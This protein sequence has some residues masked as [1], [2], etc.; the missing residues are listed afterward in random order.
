MKLGYSV[1]IILIVV[2][3]IFFALRSAK[4]NPEPV[5]ENN[6]QSMNTE[7]TNEETLPT[8]DE[9]LMTTVKEGS[10]DEAKDGDVITVNYTGYFADGTVFFSCVGKTP[11]QSTL[12]AGQVIA[13]WD[14]GVK[15]MKKGEVRR[16]VIPADMAYGEAGRPGIPPN[17]TLAFEVELLEIAP[18]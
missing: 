17:S 9:L 10:G 14:V 2:V 7:N 8:S 18:K 13:G 11:F 15:G 6:T 12:G 5:T 4:N 1:I 16:L 3:G